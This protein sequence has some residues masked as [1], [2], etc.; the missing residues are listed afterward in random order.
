MAGLN[1]IDV[2]GW[3]ASGRVLLST[4]CIAV[5]FGLAAHAADPIAIPANASD[6]YVCSIIGQSHTRAIEL[7]KSKDLSGALDMLKACEAALKKRSL[8]M[9]PKL[10]ERPTAD[11]RRALKITND[12]IFS[13]AAIHQRLGHRGE[14]ERYADMA[15][16]R[17]LL[18]KVFMAGQKRR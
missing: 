13:L 2:R 15:R 8:W 1:G 16:E 9:P 3:S 6:S 5:S 18:P 14:S 11:Q 4:L 12:V 10:P 7:W 17:N